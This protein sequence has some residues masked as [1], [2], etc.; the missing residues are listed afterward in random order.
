MSASYWFNL[1]QRNLFRV[2]RRERR[3]VR[4]PKHHPAITQ[5]SRPLC[6]TEELEDRT[7][8]TSFFSID[9]VTVAEGSSGIT[10]LIFT[11]HL[12]S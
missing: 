11:V 12:S 1:L 2:S 4:H 7:L 6:V 10:E 9:D 8:L 3:S 5:F